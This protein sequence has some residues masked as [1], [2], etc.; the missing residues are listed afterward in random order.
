MGRLA[1]KRSLSE[2]MLFWSLALNS[3][4]DICSSFQS[5]WGSLELPPEKLQLFEN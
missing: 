1:P 5:P 3:R 4:P 2:D